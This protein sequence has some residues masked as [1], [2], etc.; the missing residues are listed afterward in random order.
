MDVI[1]DIKVMAYGWGQE[2]I[3]SLI[4]SEM[5]CIAEQ[6]VCIA[7]FLEVIQ[8]LLGC[9]LVIRFE[10]AGFGGHNWW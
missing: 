6:V 5:S 1:K 7:V 4:F 2:V 10:A 3:W 8:T 9:S